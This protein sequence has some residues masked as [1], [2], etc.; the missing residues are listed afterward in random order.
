MAGFDVTATDISSEALDIAEENAERLGA[1]VDFRQED[2][3]LTSKH[4]NTQISK[5]QMWDII[6]SNPPYICEREVS[7]MCNNVLDFEPHEALFVPD[8]DPLLFYRAI[9]RYGREYLNEG[10][11]LYFEINHSFGSEMKELLTA[12]E[13]HDIIIRKDQ[14]GKERIAKAYV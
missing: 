10:G 8:N 1:R 9:A 12:E 7:D 14:Y 6:V 11:A 2:I 3:L 4:A 13:Y 5:P